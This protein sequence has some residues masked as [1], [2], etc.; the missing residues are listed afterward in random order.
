M[1]YLWFEQ[2]MSSRQRKCWCASAAGCKQEVGAKECYQTGSQLICLV[3]HL[4]FFFLSAHSCLVQ[5]VTVFALSPLCFGVYTHKWARKI[6]TEQT[7]QGMKYRATGFGLDTFYLFL[8][9]KA[10]Q[11]GEEE[12]LVIDG[13]ENLVY[14]IFGIHAIRDFC[15]S[16][17]LL[18]CV[19]I[20]LPRN[21]ENNTWGS[22]RL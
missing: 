15:L 13:R 7:N 20:A 3:L 9:D 6:I 1:V 18:L 4:S 14:F 5:S 12:Y 17:F 11:K 16:N 22:I 10:V 19:S 21:K 2:L 8:S